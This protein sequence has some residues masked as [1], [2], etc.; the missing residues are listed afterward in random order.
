[1]IRVRVKGRIIRKSDGLGKWGKYK[2]NIQGKVTKKKIRI[3]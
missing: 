2:K 1:M 3:K